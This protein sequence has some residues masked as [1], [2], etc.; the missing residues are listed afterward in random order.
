[1]DLLLKSLCVHLKL[2]NDDEFKNCSVL[3]F[4]KIV[5]EE[6]N[7]NFGDYVNMKT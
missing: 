7:E 2:V 3:R 6:L 1:M 4:G 5:D